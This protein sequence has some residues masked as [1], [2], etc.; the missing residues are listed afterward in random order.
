LDFSII[1]AII[2]IILEIWGFIWLLKYGKKPTKTEYEEWE[3]DRGLDENWRSN[4][5][6]NTTSMYLDEGLGYDIQ[7]PTNV[8]TEFPRFWNTRRDSAIKLVIIGLI[9]QIVQLTISF[10]YS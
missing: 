6:K 3:S 4:D 10:V 1:I 9:F 5:R 7:R 8:H 2:G